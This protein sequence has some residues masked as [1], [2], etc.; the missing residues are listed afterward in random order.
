M[1]GEL[2]KVVRNERTTR[3]TFCQT[4][5]RFSGS[6]CV[7]CVVCVFFT[8]VKMS[9]DGIVAWRH[10]QFAKLVFGPGSDVKRLPMS[11]LSLSDRM[12]FP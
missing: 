4:G 12:P 6:M 11:N 2:V 1:K 7:L 5:S 3:E 9:Q 8:R 10:E